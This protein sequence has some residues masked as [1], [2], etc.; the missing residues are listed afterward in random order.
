MKL[1]PT[2]YYSIEL[3]N[4][5]SIA[6]TNLKSNTLSAEQFVTDWKKQTFIGKIHNDEFE[7][8]L[9]KNF[10]GT[11]CVL[12]GKLE[13]RNGTLQIR[14][15]K[16]LKI[17]FWIVVLFVMSGLI[18]SLIRNRLD[19]LL[20]LIMTIIVFRFIFIELVFRI[21]SKTGLDKLTKIIGITKLEKNEVQ[22][23][24]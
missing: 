16:T 8:K 18:A 13:K 7:I 1:F 12:N 23:F 3:Q 17:L 9:S 20:P 6:M 11:F 15:D 10:Y 4:D 19:N 24:V 2:K 22:Q 5:S 21:I 14:V